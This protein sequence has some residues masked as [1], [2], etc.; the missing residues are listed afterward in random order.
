[1][2]SIFF[3]FKLKTIGQAHTRFRNKFIMD[4]S[5]GNYL[6]TSESSDRYHA[7]DG[8]VNYSSFLR[9][10]GNYNNNNNYNNST[11]RS[12]PYFLAPLTPVSFNY[13]SSYLP[14]ESYTKAYLEN[15]S[16]PN[17]PTADPTLTV[18]KQEYNPDDE[19]SPSSNY[20][21]Y[22]NNDAHVQS[23]ILNYSSDHDCSLFNQTT[24]SSLDTPT[25]PLASSS[26]AYT[27]SSKRSYE[28]V[29]PDGN[30]FKATV[31]ILTL[32]NSPGTPC[33][34]PRTRAS[35]KARI[36]A[37]E[38]NGCE[39]N[40]AE[41]KLEEEADFE[42]EDQS[43]QIYCESDSD[44]DDNQPSS[45][46]LEY[47]SP[48]P[49]SRWAER[50]DD[51]IAYLKE[52][53]GMSWKDISLFINGHRSW[54]AVQ[55]RYLRSLKNRCIDFTADEVHRLNQVMIK[56]WSSR[57]KRISVEM[58]PRFS[59]DRCKRKC[60]QLLGFNSLVPP[61]HPDGYAKYYTTTANSSKT[62]ENYSNLEI[63]LDGSKLTARCKRFIENNDIHEPDR[64]TGLYTAPNKYQKQ[65]R[66][67]KE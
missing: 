35:T 31:P 50:D 23:Q 63:P 66:V 55:M 14:R 20:Y 41:Q 36:T 60:L 40:Y 52:A 37:I 26:P 15:R 49:H 48:T 46:N 22:G 19:Q 7:S 13:H 61:M 32:L 58:G 25:S 45:S 27:S 33:K 64:L 11:P 16:S 9:Y 21:Q 43:G 5:P 56:D 34:K 62:K 2:P 4:S 42:F 17:R 10:G 30:V 6:N 53:R 8:Y 67:K 51:V 65:P 12:L 59:E 1:M 28:Y 18:I 39:P 3:S 57:W 47:W 44:S 29:S 24:S 54:Q 38:G